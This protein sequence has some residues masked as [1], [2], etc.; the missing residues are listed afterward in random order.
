LGSLLSTCFSLLLCVAGSLRTCL[1]ISGG[2]FSLGALGSF[3]LGGELRFLS[4]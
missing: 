4:V 2:G 1:G 3:L